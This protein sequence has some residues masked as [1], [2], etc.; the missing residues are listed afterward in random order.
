VAG[1]AADCRKIAA[2][3]VTRKSRMRIQL[4]SFVLVALALP[5][6]GCDKLG[7]DDPAKAAAAREAEGKAIGSGCR[8]AGRA[9]EDCY[10][11]NP[12]AQKA[13]VFAGWRE[14]D[15]YMRDNKMEAAKPMSSADPAAAKPDEAASQPPAAKVKAAKHP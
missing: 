14:M 1:P 8:Q 13:A 4:T 10:E 15:G 11:M 2:I 3:G 7:L 5:L 12:K 6:G 9:I